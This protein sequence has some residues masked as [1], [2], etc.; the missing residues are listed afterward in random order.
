MP[1]VP[2]DHTIAFAIDA[3][4]KASDMQ[5]LDQNIDYLEALMKTATGHTHDQ[6][7][8]SHEGGPVV[9]VDGS[10]TIPKLESNTSLQGYL[11]V[12]EYSAYISTWA[13]IA[14]VPIFIPGSAQTLKAKLRVRG[15]SATNRWWRLNTPTQASNTIQHSDTSYI[16]IGEFTL[17]VSD[18]SGWI[19]ID[20]YSD[21]QGV[22][23]T[24]F[25]S[26]GVWRL[27]G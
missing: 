10:V 6:S 24:V 20:I 7:G 9:P 12:N 13:I 2:I 4:A 25:V 22:T 19:N 21:P 11:V 1:Y 18:Q 3:A 27:E 14:S 8:G 15:D 16:W 17:D 5:K 23:H 26:E